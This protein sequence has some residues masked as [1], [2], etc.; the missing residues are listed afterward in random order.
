MPRLWITQ[1]LA[2]VVSDVRGNGLLRRLNTGLGFAIERI[3]EALA[4][5]SN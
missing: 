1:G 4:H 3:I 2:V 5:K